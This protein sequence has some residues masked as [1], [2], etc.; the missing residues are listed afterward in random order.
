MPRIIPAAQTFQLC[1][2]SFNRLHLQR[3]EDCKVTSSVR[4]APLFIYDTNARALQLGSRKNVPMKTIITLTTIPPRFSAILPTLHSLCEQNADISRIL[5]TIPRA[6]RKRAFQPASL[7][8]LPDRVEIFD[9]D[10]DFGPATK[11]LPAALHFKNEDVRIIYCD[12]DRVYNSDWAS[13]LMALSDEMPDKCIVD[14][15]DPVSAID[16]RAAWNSQVNQWLNDLS[17]GLYGKSHRRRV[18]RMIPASGIVDIAKGYGGVL[19]RPEFLHPAVFDIPDAYWAVDDIWLSGHLALN[20]TQIH[21]S[22]PVPR[23]RPTKVAK[24][25]ALLDLEM[26]GHGRDS[27]NLACVDHFRRTH[28]IWG[29]SGPQKV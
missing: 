17:L 21:K 13:R 7:P 11:V 12:D 10:E 24:R 25:F 27:L 15:G 23:S 4:V 3:K 29:E 14:A 20:G 26:E 9:C 16:A 22:G 19:I 18:R 5:L 28:G 6:Y 2:S 1:H 8:P